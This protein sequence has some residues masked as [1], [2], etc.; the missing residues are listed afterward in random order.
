[1]NI[2]WKVRI[3]SKTFWVSM[4]SFIILL[5]TQV[6]FIFNIKFD[7]PYWFS[8]LTPIIDTVFGILSLLGIVV[9]H[10]T[11]GIGDTKQVLTYEEPRSDHDVQTVL[12]YVNSIE[13]EEVPECNSE[14]IEK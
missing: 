10:T 14:N 1:M 4:I 13:T 6:L 5:I 3:K 9:D 8:V 11:A 7:G 12:D 2:N